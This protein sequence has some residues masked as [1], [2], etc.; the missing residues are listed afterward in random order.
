MK[1]VLST[2]MLTM[3]MITSLPLGIFVE[4]AEGSVPTVTI[5]NPSKGVVAL[6]GKV[7]YTVTFTDANTI[8]LEP[9][10]I[11]VA[12]SGVTMTKTVTGSGNTRTIILSNIQGPVGQVV[13]IALKAGIATNDFGSS[14]VTG[15]T[16]AF[17]IGP[18][19]AKPVTEATPV[20]P[21]VPVTEGTP[22]T[23]N[24]P[25]TPGTPVTEG[26]PVTPGIPVTEAKPYEDK[27]RPSISITNPSSTTVYYGGT[28]TYTVKYMD[29]VGL[30]GLNLK[31]SDITLNG[32]TADVSVSGSG[33]QRKV[34]LSNVKGTEGLKYITVASGTAWDAAGNRAL[35]IP[36]SEA[37]TLKV[38][39]AIPV[40]DETD[41]EAPVMS[42]SAPS[43]S[44]INNG[45]TVKYVVTYTDNDA[46]DT[47]D[48]KAS[49]VTLNGFTADIKITGS[50]N[51][52]IITL[53]NIQGAVNSTNNISIAAG[54]AWDAA[55]NKA[56]SVDNTEVFKIVE[57]INNNT[58]T[59]TPDDKKPDTTVENKT[60]NQ[61]PSD[62]VKNPYTG[63]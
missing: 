29:D 45:Q 59:K 62:W 13:S 48:L 40:V 32:F 9:S 1:K 51:R 55:G 36:A 2:L 54:T 35:G 21:G 15:K 18:A 47:I 39:E 33:Y 7:Q 12:G 58:D 19:E 63:M 44:E 8:N 4:A 41:D 46:I 11:G 43:F 6:G 53:S 23:E 16:I 60:E 56:N 27:T 28:V 49:D 61:K 22:V 20:T 10:D 50:G 42:V 30:S 5:S 25:V 26:T 24:K 17:A 3:F 37:F 31:A 38:R 52:R 14:A 34:T 57:V